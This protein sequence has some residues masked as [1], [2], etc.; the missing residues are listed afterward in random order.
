MTP[1]GSRKKGSAIR[2]CTYFGNV[3]PVPLLGGWSNNAGKTPVTAT[4]GARD[5]RPPGAYCS[6]GGPRMVG[7]TAHTHSL[8]IKCHL[9]AYY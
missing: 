6:K 8:D 5:N 9:I 2:L 4:V 7:C 1:Y 3:K